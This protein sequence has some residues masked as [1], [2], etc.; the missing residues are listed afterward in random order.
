MLAGQREDSNK[1][2]TGQV[3]HGRSNLTDPMHRYRASAARPRSVASR[4]RGAARSERHHFV[5]DARRRPR[6]LRPVDVTKSP[7][8]YISTSPFGSVLRRRRQRLP[9]RLTAEDA[10]PT[11][12]LQARRRSTPTRSPSVRRRGSRPVRKT[13]HAAAVA[14]STARVGVELRAC[15]PAHL[16]PAEQRRLVD[17]VAGD[18]ANHVRQPARIAAQIDDE[19]VGG[20]EAIDAPARSAR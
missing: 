7:T 4:P 18:A 17:D 5:R 10:R 6:A 2:G 15:T 11:E 3:K 1:A 14:A 12:A 13:A 8:A 19:P 20:A 16:H 9:H